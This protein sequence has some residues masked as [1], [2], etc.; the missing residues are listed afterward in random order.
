MKS[1]IHQTGTKIQG[2]NSHKENCFY[3][4]VPK[5]FLIDFCDIKCQIID[6]VIEN[7]PKPIENDLK[8]LK[9]Q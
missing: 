8:L 9:G 6:Y 7:Y 3:D 4:L 5:K 1:Y 2:Y